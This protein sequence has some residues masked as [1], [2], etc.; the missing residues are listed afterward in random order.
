VNTETR[1]S[2]I[3]RNPQTQGGQAES[4]AAD[5][6]RRAASGASEE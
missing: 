4:L 5:R 3:S 2:C 1:T 6:G